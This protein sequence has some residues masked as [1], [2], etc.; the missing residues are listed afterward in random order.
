MTLANLHILVILTYQV[1]HVRVHGGLG[2]NYIQ[3]F[4]VPSICMGFEVSA[5]I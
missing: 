5:Y 4:P 1:N 2:T 3:H